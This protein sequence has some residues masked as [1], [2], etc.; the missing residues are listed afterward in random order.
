M[1]WKDIG[2]ALATGGAS[3][4]PGA[5]DFVD[6]KF[7]GGD[8]ARAARGAGQI[9][10]NAATTA[11]NNVRNQFN[12]TAGTYQPY[13][14]SG[15]QNLGI[16]NSGL[17]SGRFDQPQ[18]QGSQPF[19]FDP[20]K[21]AQ[22]PAYQFALSQGVK[23]ADMGAAARGGVLGGGQQKALTGLAGGLASQFEGQYYN[24]AANTQ[25][26]NY[27][28]AANTYGVNQTNLNNQFG[29]YSNLAGLGQQ[30]TGQL[31]ALSGQ[32]ADT[33]ANILTGGAA[34]QAAGQVGAANARSTALNGLLNLGGKLGGAALAGSGGISGLAGM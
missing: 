33:Q 32:N 11:G 28:Q 27:G 12:Q 29:R 14:Q 5:A 7:L 18:F 3:L 21:I 9:Q 16:L 23:G 19:S 24:Q 25:A 26:Q 34:A 15:T 13:L 30:A 1:S 20:A 17:A 2:T 10:Q 31:G 22:D 8:A 6:N 4:I